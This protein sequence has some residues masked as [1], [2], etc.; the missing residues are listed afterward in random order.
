MLTVTKIFEFEA[1]HFLPEYEGKCHNLH[2]HTYKLEIT[3]SGSPVNISKANNNKHYLDEGHMVCDFGDIK[4]IVNTSVI[5]SL[6]HSELNEFV[7]IPTAEN[8]VHWIKDRL[9]VH[10][11]SKLYSIRLWETSTSYAEWRKE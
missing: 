5:D 11:G 4:R 3:L 7:S 6:D 8:L 1:A 2:G 9:F 10:F